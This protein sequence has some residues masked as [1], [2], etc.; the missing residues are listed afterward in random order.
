MPKKARPKKPDIDY[1]RTLL[2]VVQ[3]S[4]GTTAFRHLFLRRGKKSIDILRRGELSCAFFV[5]NVLHGLG[6]LKEVHA[7]VDGTVKDLRASGWKKIRR[8]RAGAVIT[9]APIVYAD[10][11]SHSHI[12]FVVSAQQAI[13]T[14]YRRRKVVVHPIHYGRRGSATYRPAETLWFHPRLQS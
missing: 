9:W 7:T 6:L 2:A 10:H 12:G 4:V 1:R 11:E 13:S 14:S 5:S 3:G 8:P